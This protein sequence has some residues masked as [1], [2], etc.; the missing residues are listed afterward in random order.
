M[1]IS[2]CLNTRRIEWIGPIRQMGP[3]RRTTRGRGRRRVR[4]RLR[5]AL[6]A[7]PAFPTFLPRLGLELDQRESQNT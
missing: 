3:I 1:S 7:I 5:W 2:E 6:F 4:G